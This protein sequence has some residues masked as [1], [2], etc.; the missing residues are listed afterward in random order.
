MKR[1]IAAA[2]SVL[3]GITALTA[4]GDKEEESG[5]GGMIDGG[6]G[7]PDNYSLAGEEME[8]G[9]SVVEL[10]PE[11]NE[12]VRV[13]I[14]FDKRY[15][16]EEDYGAIYRIT[17]YIAA[18]NENDHDL[19]KEIFYDGYL[20]YAAEQNGIEDGDAYID[21]F[22][23]SLEE[24]LGEGFEIDYIDVSGCYDAEDNASASYFEQ[25]DTVLTQLAGSDDI[26]DK[27]DYRRVVE[28]GGNTT[29]KTPKG[30]Y[31]FINHERPFMLCIYRIDGQYYL[32]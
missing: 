17:D 21:S 11:T 29:Y 22:E 4:C 28:I 31:L 12:N 30:S 19:I 13:M 2:L 15:F 9:A 14:G 7:I 32:F 5:S 6:Q 3:L 20:E 1:I 23:T 25:T 27:V 24:S 16:S 10:K 18:M 26:L 8:Y